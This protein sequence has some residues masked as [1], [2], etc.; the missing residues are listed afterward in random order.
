MT[1]R[2]QNDAKNREQARTGMQ[3]LRERGRNIVDLDLDTVTEPVQDQND[4][5][6]LQRDLDLE[7]ELQAEA[8]LAIENRNLEHGIQYQNASKKRQVQQKNAALVDLDFNLKEFVNAY[9]RC[10]ITMIGN[11]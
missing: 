3:V 10:R 6:D 2:L 8:N 9:F 4:R 1:N 11:I 7:E 5:I